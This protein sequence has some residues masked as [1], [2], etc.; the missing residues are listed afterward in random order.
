LISR[1]LPLVLTLAAACAPPLY[2]NPEDWPRRIGVSGV[3]RWR[4]S[5]HRRRA[6]PF[7]APY[8]KNDGARLRLYAGTE[9][10]TIT[11]IGHATMLVQAGGLT[12]LTDPIFSHDIQGLFT[13]YAPP[14]VALRDLPPVDVV[15]ISHAH[16][17][18]LDE[19]S[20][21]A[22]GPRVHFVVGKGLGD[23]FRARGLRRVT[24]LGWWESTTITTRWGA[25]AV[26]TMVPAQHWSQR[27]ANDQNRHLWGGYV[28]DAGGRRFYFAGDTGWPAAFAEVGR[29]FPRID[30]AFLPIGAYEPRWFMR[31]QHISPDEAA[32]AFDQLRARTLVPMHW[33]TFRLS[34]EPMAE[35]PR[36]LYRAMGAR[37]NR[38]LF[39]PIG[40]SYVVDPPSG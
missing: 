22:L 5:P 38:I 32:R 8:Q 21:I 14:G 1:L 7:I 3:V 13:R 37:A 27:N 26:V 30:F 35:P 29:R 20:V 12:F 11:W 25:R 17:D 28:F 39:L 15:M 31:A 6:E 40:G 19:E 10:M 9:A 36:L 4:L 33:A 34:D 18:H 23:W 16:F 24:E 2:H